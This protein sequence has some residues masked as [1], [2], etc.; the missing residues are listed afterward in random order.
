M[1]KK[2]VITGVSGFI[3]SALADYLDKDYDIIGIDREK[4]EGQKDRP[5]FKKD[6]NDGL[7]DMDDI[8]AV[9]HL[10]AR[11]GVRSSHEMFD[12]VCK[13]NILATQRVIAK[14][15]DCWKPKKLL[16]ASSSSVYGNSGKKDEPSREDDQVNPMSPYAMSKVAGE[17]LV[18]TYKNAGLL[19]DIKVVSLRFFT[20]YGPNQRNE[21]AIRAFTDW[22]L[23]GQPIQLHGTG[24][25]MRD[26]TNIEDI[27]SGIEMLLDCDMDL[28][29]HDIYNIGSNDCHSIN[30]IV[31]LICEITGRNVTINY[32]P[33]NIWDS[34]VTLADISRLKELGWSPKVKFIDGLKE[35]I[36]WQM[37]YI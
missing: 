18:T 27:C 22:I 37:K 11:P 31:R 28:I 15:I 16:L 23:Q 2:V 30:E 5:F 24:E 8:Y 33:K 20:V 3:G 1:K 13:D 10:A 34:D 32:Q 19:N 7:V 29:T 17:Q 14:C 4:W 26:F 6:I 9:I 12:E 21:L 25:Q 35:Q 36:K